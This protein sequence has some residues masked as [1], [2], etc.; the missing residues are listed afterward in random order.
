M[1][2]LL[3]KV[4]DVLSWMAASALVGAGLVQLCSD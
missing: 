1:K 3:L 2:R 4:A